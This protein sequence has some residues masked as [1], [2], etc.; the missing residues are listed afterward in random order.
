MPKDTHIKRI[1]DSYF[2]Y[3]INR[4]RYMQMKQNGTHQVSMFYNIQ[5]LLIILQHSHNSHI[6]DSGLMLC[7]KEINNL[8][9][10][11]PLFKH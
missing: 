7:D 9:G 10:L 1:V 11:V 6:I 3:F 8:L 4:N 2:W 5:A